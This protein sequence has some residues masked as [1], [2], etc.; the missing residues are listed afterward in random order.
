MSTAP[1]RSV[2]IT[3]AS[4]PIGSLAPVRWPTFTRWCAVG[5]VVVGSTACGSGDDDDVER[6]AEDL[7]AETSGALDDEQATCVA[8]ALDDA[9]GDDAFRRVIDAADGRSGSAD[10]R[11]Q[12]IDIFAECDALDAVM[13]GGDT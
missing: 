1:S 13:L 10:V 6:L 12:V 7:V 4:C 11:T 9:F 2:L 5:V 3:G 8:A